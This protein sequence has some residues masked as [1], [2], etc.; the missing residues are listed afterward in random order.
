MDNLFVLNSPLQYLNALEAINLFK[1]KNN[2]LLLKNSGSQLN[3][4]Q[5]KKLHERFG[6]V[7]KEIHEVTSQ[8]GL[9]YNIHPNTTK[10]LNSLNNINYLFSGSIGESLNNYVIND[11]RPNK[12]FYLD[13]GTK[14]IKFAEKE[15]LNRLKNWLKFYLGSKAYM[16]HLNI[17]Y[18]TAYYQID[19]P[20]NYIVIPNKYNYMISHVRK[21]FTKEDSCYFILS[22][23]VE[24]SLI[25]AALFSNYA[26]NIIKYYNGNVKFILHRYSDVKLMNSLINVD[27]KNIIGFDNIIEYEMIYQKKYPTKIASFISSAL[28][29]LSFIFLDSD[30]T[31]FTLPNKSINKTES[32]QFNMYYELLRANDVKIVEYETLDIE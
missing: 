17:N 30:F 7:F 1:S 24:K 5:I 32:N 21:D 29:N 4:S 19:W 23:V 22:P 6:S 27:N 2:I 15:K 11:I 13:D 12:V 3:Q 16:N 25:S 14:T 31:C 9:L 8:N 26:N 20:E 18:F 10:L 28:I